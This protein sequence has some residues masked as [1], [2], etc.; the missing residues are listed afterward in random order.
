MSSGNKYVLIGYH[1]NANCI[2]GHPVKDQRSPTLVTAWQN[3]HNKLATTGNAPA[4]WVL[5]NEISSDLKMA[6][7]NNSTKFQLVPLHLH[8]R[9]LAERA[10]Q[11]W[12]NHFKA[13]IFGRQHRIGGILG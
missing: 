13:G 5:D 3:P 12:K 1:Y 10:I 4:V 11:T 8:R 2:V 9:N 7:K 6:F